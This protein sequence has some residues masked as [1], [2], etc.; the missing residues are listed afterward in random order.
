MVRAALVSTAFV[1]G[2][3]L[4]GCG[5]SGGGDALQR[6]RQAMAEEAKAANLQKQ[7]A[8]GQGSSPAVA[9]AADVPK[10]AFRVPAGTVVE[11]LLSKSMS[12][13]SAGTGEE[14]AGR[15]AKDLKTAEGRV[16]MPAGAEVAG[17]IVL[18]SDGSGLRRKH[19]L[20]L[21]IYRLRKSEKDPWVEVLSR[22]SI[23]EGSTN[24]PVVLQA[25]KLL[26]FQLSSATMFP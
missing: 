16:V 12:S 1:A 5:G 23:E 4:V 3:W 17:R 15:L 25:Q 18:A 10:P 9:P 7:Q 19:E 2:V 8:A 20:E 22:T 24:A 6:E 14:W 13:R 26:T 11:V 21:R